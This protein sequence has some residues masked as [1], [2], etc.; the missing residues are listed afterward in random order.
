[1][2]LIQAQQLPRLPQTAVWVHII[3]VQQRRQRRQKFRVMQQKFTFTIRPLVP[4]L[5]GIRAAMNLQ[6]QFVVPGGQLRAAFRFQAAEKVDDFA[7][8]HARQGR[9]G[10]QLAGV[11]VHFAGRAATAVAITITHQHDPL[12]LFMF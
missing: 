1:M 6:V 9:E 11:F 8:L 7:L 3:A 12:R 5:R 2:K 10:S 4:A